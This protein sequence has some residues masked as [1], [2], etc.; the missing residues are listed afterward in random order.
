MI[1][2]QQFIHD[3][4][5][6]IHKNYVCRRFGIL[7]DILNAY[8]SFL[9]L[10][11]ESQQLRETMPMCFRTSYEF[12]VVVKV[13]INRQCTLLAQ[14]MTLVELQASQHS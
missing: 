12:R 6:S 14:A 7:I 11:P 2:I 9:V 13:F 4:Q 1:I 5:K 10:W 3:L 8:Y